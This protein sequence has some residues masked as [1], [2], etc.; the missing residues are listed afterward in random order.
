[1]SNLLYPP[2]AETYVEADISDDDDSTMATENG[3][4][5]SFST[6]DEDGD[7]LVQLGPNV[8]LSQKMAIEVS[9]PSTSPKSITQD[10]IEAFLASKHGQCDGCRPGQCHAMSCFT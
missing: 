3:G 7:D 2:P 5:S 10:C 8:K 4:S 9:L 6:E 1:M